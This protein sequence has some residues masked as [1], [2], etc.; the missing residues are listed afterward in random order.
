VTTPLAAVWLASHVYREY[1]IL[2]LWLGDRNG[3]YCV[4]T[5]VTKSSIPEQAGEET[6]GN[7]QTQVTLKNGRWSG[8]AGGDDRLYH[9]NS[10]WWL[11]TR[12]S[13]K[14]RN[15]IVELTGKWSTVKDWSWNQTKATKS[16][17]CCSP[18][19]TLCYL[20]PNDSQS[21]WL[22]A[23]LH[24][25]CYLVLRQLTGKVTESCTVWRVVML[26]M[27]CRKIRL[28]VIIWNHGCQIN[29]LM[30]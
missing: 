23:E 27:F 16:V 26:S 6:E 15:L 10:E 21:V 1:L 2:Y 25:I 29:V 18:S 30:H 13:C 12:K 11:F 24:L 7:R 20:S 22:V 17:S 8:V 4:K 5:C 14:I 9:D 3:I 28:V 19:T